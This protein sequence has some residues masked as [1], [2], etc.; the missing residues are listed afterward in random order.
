MHLSH[1]HNDEEEKE[2]KIKFER[3]NFL[4]KLPRKRATEMKQMRETRF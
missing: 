3:K 1:K 4:P 2:N